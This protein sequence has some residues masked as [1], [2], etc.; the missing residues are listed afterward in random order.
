MDQIQE[1]VN[2]VSGDPVM[3]A[4][5]RAESVASSTLQH[6]LLDAVLLD[7]HRT[8]ARMLEEEDHSRLLEDAFFLPLAVLIVGKATPKVIKAF[9]EH[10]YGAKTQPGK[11]GARMAD[12]AFLTC[13]AARQKELF[14]AGFLSVNQHA[15]EGM[16]SSDPAV[17]DLWSSLH[18]QSEKPRAQTI[19]SATRAIFRWIP[20]SDRKSHTSQSKATR[21]EIARR[22]ET[23]IEGF[24]QTHYPS[25]TPSEQ[26]EAF[27]S[28]PPSVGINASS[29][30][31]SAL[32][33][34]V[35]IDHLL[36]RTPVLRSN[37][38]SIDLQSRQTEGH[39][40]LL[41]HALLRSGFCLEDFNQDLVAELLKNTSQ[42]LR[43]NENPTAAVGHLWQEV[44]WRLKSQHP[45]RFKSLPLEIRSS[46]GSLRLLSHLDDMG[47][48]T[49]F[50]EMLEMQL[51]APSASINRS[52]PR[53]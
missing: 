53:L 21:Q 10:G 12:I 52:G 38:V 5:F 44:S 13:N 4:V 22:L 34:K 19:P 14:D 23:M 39:Q 43:R 3:Q 26:W 9:D 18:I 16:G 51:A 33:M 1:L 46:P 17:F 28:N 29:T 20:E 36:D 41:A 8:V 30:A 50:C 15:Y 27:T 32:Y 7:D 11:G 25:T 45:D 24:L 40:A 35:F 42:A 48:R 31:E 47:R 6:Q 2:L 49:A 37:R